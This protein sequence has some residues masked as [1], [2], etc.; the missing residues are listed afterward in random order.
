MNKTSG[1]D[2]DNELRSENHPRWSAL[3]LDTLSAEEEAVLQRAAPDLYERYRPL[4][5]DR[6]AARV[7]K[8][9]AAT[10]KSAT[11]PVRPE[12]LTPAWWAWWTPRAAFGGLALAA[13]VVIGVVPMISSQRGD[14]LHYEVAPPR[15]NSPGVPVLTTAESRMDVAL[16]PV[17]EIKGPVAL[18]GVALINP[19]TGRAYPWHVDLVP[20]RN[21]EIFLSGKRIELFPGVPAGE[22]DVYIAVG[23]PGPPLTEAELRSLAG[24]KPRDDKQVLVIPVVLPEPCTGTKDRP[25]SAA[26]P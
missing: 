19:G 3:T 6:M 4:D 9:L 15:G 16:S 17:G 14:P 18:R 11:A 24:Q 5:A 7:E 23:R 2:D 1:M 8:A 13:L 12:S 21:N 22:W 10:R 20:T 25:C 26:T